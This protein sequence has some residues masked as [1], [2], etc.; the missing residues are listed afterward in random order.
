MSATPAPWAARN[1]GTESPRYAVVEVV[2][3]PG[4]AAGAKRRLAIGGAGE[5]VTELGRRSVGALVVVGLLGRD[6]CGGVAHEQRG[7]QESD[8]RDHG[9][10]HD[11]YIA[12]GE[13]GC[14]PAAQPGG[15]SDAAVAGGLVYS[16][17]Q[18]AAA[19]RRGRS[20]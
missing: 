17:R 1:N 14:Q 6:V 7:Q 5:R 16:E 9:A 12:R 10:A 8:G 4:L 3:E 2:D 19:G 20:S 11:Q 13:G 15:E 18:S